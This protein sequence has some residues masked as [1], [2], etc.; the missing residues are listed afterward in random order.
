MF[1]IILEH[2]GQPC[3]FLKHFINKVVWL[4]KHLNKSNLLLY[5]FQ[6]HLTQN[7]CFMF[8]E[9]EKSFFGSWQRNPKLVKWLRK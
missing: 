4:G 9:G 1:A 2:F 6:F 7:D 5:I 8:T 3:C